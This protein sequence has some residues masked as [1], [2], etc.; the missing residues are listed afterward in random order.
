[1]RISSKIERMGVSESPK[2][3]KGEEI[4]W[5]LPSLKKSTPMNPLVDIGPMDMDMVLWFHLEIFKIITKKTWLN[6]A[7]YKSDIHYE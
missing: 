7:Q 5:H 1:M 2:V 3:G 6:I 4:F